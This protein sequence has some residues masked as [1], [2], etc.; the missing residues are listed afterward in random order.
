MKTLFVC[1]VL[2]AAVVVV[3]PPGQGKTRCLHLTN[4]CD[5]ITFQDAGPLWQGNWDFMC[6]G[7][8][9]TTSVL[10]N[11]SANTLSN[12]KDRRELSSRPYSNFEPYLS[13]YVYQFSFRSFK[14]GQLFDLHGS[15]GISRGIAVFQQNQPFTISNGA[16]TGGDVD[17]SKPRMSA[18]VRAMFSRQKPVSTSCIH[19]T[20]FCDTIVFSALD[21]RNYGNWDWACVGDWKT[22][23]VI[24]DADHRPELATRPGVAYGYV[25]P[26]STQFSFKPNKLFDLY[27]ADGSTPIVAART[28]EAFTVTSGGCTAADVDKSK[29]R[30]I[31][32]E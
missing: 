31:S 23:P 8:W 26:Y 29:P 16:C 12:I 7:D 20:N 27:E 5:T 1:C 22:T 6:I 13:D 2:L 9:T 17:I 18:G 4:F 25:F 10:G 28:N 24:G 14:S 21:G 3:V 11:A 15:S 32:L 30:I 19:F